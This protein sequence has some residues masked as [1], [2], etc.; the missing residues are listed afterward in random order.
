MEEGKQKSCLPSPNYAMSRLRYSRRAAVT[1]LR[2]QCP[3]LAR[4]IDLQGPLKLKIG[5][6]PDLFTALA[7]AIV[8][9]QLSGK[10]AATIYSRFSALFGDGG[11]NPRAANTLTMARLRSVGLSQNKALAI[12]DL[13]RKS[14]EGHLA[15]RHRIARMSDAQV[16]ESLVQVRGVGPWTAQML[17]IFNLGR[18]DVMPAA[19]LGVQKGVQA[20]Y[21]MKTMPHPDAVLRRTR[22]LAP[23]RSAAS[24]YF[25]CAA[26]TVLL[27]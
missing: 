18:P 5:T 27:S 13:A 12:Q 26:D 11:P 25:W 3:S 21:R 9:Q 2:S 8:Y 10:A 4:F 24:W 14:L 22:H 6:E 1:H 20:V 7:R 16:I 19:D 15:S 23:F 17:L